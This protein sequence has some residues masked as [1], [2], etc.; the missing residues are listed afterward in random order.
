M[1]SKVS[2]HTP[3]GRSTREFERESDSKRFR[4]VQ[5]TFH[6]ALA[7][8]LEISLDLPAEGFHWRF[9]GADER[10]ERQVLG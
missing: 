4:G 6:W 3:I 8:P 2:G 5:E 1:F 10:T 7:F 9:S